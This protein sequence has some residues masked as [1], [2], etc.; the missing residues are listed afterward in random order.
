MKAFF[1]TAILIFLV[2]NSLLA[3]GIFS[4]TAFKVDITPSSGLDMW[5]YS[6]R[7]GQSTGT[8]DPLYAKGILLSDGQTQIALITLD[9]GRTFS[10]VSMELVREIAQREGGIDE[11]LFF[12]SHTHSGPSILDRSSREEIPKWERV[13]LKKISWAILQ[14]TQNLLPATL[15]SGSGETLI[16]H[17]RIRSQSDGSVE[18]FWRNATKIP[19]SPVDDHVGVLRIDDKTGSPIAIL[20]NYSCHPVVLGPDNLQYSADYPGAMSQIVESE[21]EGAV[22]LFL[23]GAPGDINPY[24]DKTPLRKNGVQLMQETGHQLGKEV[25]RIARAIRTTSPAVPSLQ[26]SLETLP[27]NF[28]WD[29]E[30]V[31]SNLSGRKTA[32][33]YKDGQHYE[34]LFSRNLNLPVTTLL[35]NR[36]I[37]LTGMPGEPFVDFAIQA[38][39]RFPAKTTFFAGYANGHFGY[40]PTLEGAVRGGY[41]GNTLG[42][43]IE[44]GAGERMLDR[45]LIEVYEMLGNLKKEPG[46]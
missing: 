7:Q 17:N 33:R 12:A 8:L 45:S 24:F 28:R 2:Q 19:T 11:V 10:F 43:W 3:S 13:M 9:L 5:G 37:V 22:C 21:I 14:A 4:A 16:G 34:R 26:Y 41:G 18:M 32:S 31:L 6:A 40:F 1:A 46:E 39:Q 20:V 27:F 44:V 30:L 29:K 42:T 25:V 38:R 36:E 15:G 35:I 23:Q